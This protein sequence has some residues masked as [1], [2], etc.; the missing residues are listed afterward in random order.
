MRASACSCKT[1]SSFRFNGLEAPTSG[2][3]GFSNRQDVAVHI[4]NFDRL[5]LDE[6]VEL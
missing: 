5:N 1:P 3:F 4:C 6:F 2:P